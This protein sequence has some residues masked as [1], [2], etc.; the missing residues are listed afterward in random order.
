MPVH[1]VLHEA[2]SDKEAY[3]QGYEDA[4][5]SNP[6]RDVEGC[7]MCY[8][9]GYIAGTHDRREVDSSGSSNT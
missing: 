1:E 6:L 9:M 3:T 7:Q 4:F 2:G 8:S 5:E